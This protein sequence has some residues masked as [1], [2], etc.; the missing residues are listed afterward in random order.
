MAKLSKDRIFIV[1]SECDDK[2]VKKHY[3]NEIGDDNYHCA[4]CGISV[5]M[6]EVL[7]LQLDHINGI[8]TDNRW[9]NLRLLCPNCHSQTDTYAGK[10]GHAASGITEEQLITAIE[11]SISISAALRVVKLDVGRTEYFG[12]A[13]KLILDGKAI[14]NKT[15][16]SKFFK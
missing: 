8:H 7:T 4:L 9:Q 12:W 2:T 5:W 11:K 16:F 14:L 1:N 13:K 6:D 10:N 3:L 15:T